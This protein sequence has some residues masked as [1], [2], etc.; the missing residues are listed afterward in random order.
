M[1]SKPNAMMMPSRVKF[2]EKSVLLS[3]DQLMVEKPIE[4]EVRVEYL[5]NYKKGEISGCEDDS[6]QV[7][8]SAFSLAAGS[9]RVHVNLL[10]D[11]VLH[12]WTR[13]LRVINYL[14]ALPKQLKQRLH[15]VPDKN[16][17][18]CEAGDSPWNPTESEKEAEK[19]LF[20]YETRVIKE[21]MKS[22]QIQEYE[23]TH[24]ILSGK[25]GS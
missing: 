9:A 11:P 15:L 4:G 1:R 7:L 19:S 14:L 12:G 17:V 20:R 8:N 23:E 6:D 22:E 21:C 25:N 3:H 5:I 24:S 10:V 13:T 18:I 2:N 16:C